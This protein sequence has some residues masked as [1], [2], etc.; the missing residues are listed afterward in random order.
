MWLVKC[1]VCLD[2]N[3]KPKRWRETCKDCADDI[4]RK[5]TKETG[6]LVD[7]TE[8]DMYEREPR[9]VSRLWWEK[10]WKTV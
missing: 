3:K 10:D 8:A 5:H 6:H 4:A 1:R 9:R 2:D 7:I